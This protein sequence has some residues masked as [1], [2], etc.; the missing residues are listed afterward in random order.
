M[1]NAA[2]A[3]YKAYYEDRENGVVV[4]DWE[5]LP[6]IERDLWRLAAAAAIATDVAASASTK[7]MAERRARYAV[8]LPKGAVLGLARGQTLPMEL[9]ESD[10]SRS[11]KRGWSVGLE[12]GDVFILTLPQGVAP[13]FPAGE[14]AARDLGIEHET[15][16]KVAP[17]PGEHPRAKG[18]AKH[19]VAMVYR[20]GTFQGLPQ[21]S[22]D[23]WVEV[24]I[25]V[26]SNL[27][28]SVVAR[29]E[30]LEGDK[31]EK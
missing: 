24:T 26:F 29:L 28:G 3:A 20:E 13:L 1:I 22:I 15:A 18:I 11:L 23:K 10:G 19:F 16:A 17:W 30:A 12:A 8:W 31:E 25:R 9:L 5:E 2:A 27:F 7:P 4:P 6:K 21:S 14:E